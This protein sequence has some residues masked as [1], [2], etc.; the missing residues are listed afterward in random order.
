MA[1]DTVANR[2]MH[3]ACICILYYSRKFD[4]VIG[5]LVFGISSFGRCSI[6]DGICVV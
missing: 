4:Y 6:M 1:G 5:V 3:G 2:L